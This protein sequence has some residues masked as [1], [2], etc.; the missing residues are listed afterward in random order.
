[1]SFEKRDRLRFHILH[2]HEKPRPHTCEVCAKSFSQSSSLPFRFGSFF[3]L[4]HP[5]REIVSV[6][7]FFTC[8]RNTDL[9]NVGFVRKVSVSLQVFPFDLVH[10]SF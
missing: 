9:I 5:K 6:F 2:V 10:F 3:F 1:M 7:T 8:M 4:G